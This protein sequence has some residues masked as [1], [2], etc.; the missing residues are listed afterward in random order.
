MED[1]TDTDTSP[2]Q[3]KTACP[4]GKLFVEYCSGVKLEKTVEDAF[5]DHLD[6]C[7]ACQKLYRDL[8]PDEFGNN[9]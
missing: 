9:T 2:P 7:A 3:A 1:P 5:V 4:S 8:H 6:G